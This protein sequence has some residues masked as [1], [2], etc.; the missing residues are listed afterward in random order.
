MFKTTSANGFHVTFKN[1]CTISVQWNPGNYVSDRSGEYGESRESPTA[2][3][4]AWGPDG[5]WIKLGQNDDVAGWQTPE[6][7]IKL[8]AEVACQ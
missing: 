7:V 6:D 5:Q 1:G 8:M 2:E 3:V 4:A